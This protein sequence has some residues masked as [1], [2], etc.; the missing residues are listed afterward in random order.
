VQADADGDGKIIT[1]IC[2]R[3]LRKPMLMAM[4]RIITMN[5]KSNDQ[6]Q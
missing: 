6:N 3:L 2:E 5:I 4:V 1:I